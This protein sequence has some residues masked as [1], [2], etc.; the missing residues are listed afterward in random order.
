MGNPPQWGSIQNKCIE[1]KFGV[2]HL[3]VYIHK[4]RSLFK[5]ERPANIIWHFFNI[6][7]AKKKRKTTATTRLR[8]SVSW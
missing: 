4:Q 1:T 5:L 2:S 7:S 3:H 6:F 8:K